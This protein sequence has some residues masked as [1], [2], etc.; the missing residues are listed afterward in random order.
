MQGSSM[1]IN[2]CSNH[3]ECEGRSSQITLRKGFQAKETVRGHMASP[4]FANSSTLFIIRSKVG[5]AC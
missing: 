5:I 2:I 3:E 1:N 4:C